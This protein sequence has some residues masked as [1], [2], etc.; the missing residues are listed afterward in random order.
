LKYRADITAGSLKVAESRVIAGL[1]LDGVDDEGWRRAIY[2]QNV[3]QAR[4]PA[5]AKRVARLLRF[6]LETMSADLWCLIRDGSQTVSTHAILAAAVKH[7][8]LLGDFLYLVVREQYHQFSQTLPKTLWEEYLEG[9]RAREAEMPM[10]HES[11]RKKLGTV[12]YH[13]LEQS[14][15]IESTRSL[16]LQTVHISQPVLDYLERHEERYVLRCI[17][18]SP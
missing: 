17:T 1:L 10:W 11:T 18:V 8:S 13:I 6:R 12:T 14:G 15:Y 7:S 3:L 5:T 9:C 2:D 16:R 4:N